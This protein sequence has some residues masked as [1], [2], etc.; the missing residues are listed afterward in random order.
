MRAMT[1]DMRA[2][3]LHPE[4]AELF[5]LGIRTYETRSWRTSYRGPLAIH[6]STRDPDSPPARRDPLNRVA[7]DAI[8][9]GNGFKRGV[10]VAVVDLVDCARIGHADGM[11][12]LT[13]DSRAH[14]WGPQIRLR[15]EQAAYGDFTPGR[16]AWVT[17]AV[18]PLNEPVACRGRQGLWL[19]PD[20]VALTLRR[21]LEPIA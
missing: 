3:T 15:P 8:P 16:Y 1:L 18:R 7:L 11:V 4:H 13:L 5:R 21:S 19:V 10:I 17:R 14:V 2:L 9:H 20:D 6:A 12:T